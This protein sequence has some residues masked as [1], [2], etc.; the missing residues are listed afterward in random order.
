LA[1][2]AKMPA[3]TTY[4]RPRVSYRQSGLAADH[5]IV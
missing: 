2:L 1:I 3:K 5:S 4:P